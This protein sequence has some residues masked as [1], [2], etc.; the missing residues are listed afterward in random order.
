ML[1]EAS[2]KAF[3]DCSTIFGDTSRSEGSREKYLHTLLQLS[4]CS[5]LSPEELL[6]LPK[7]ETE[8]L[9]QGFAGSIARNGASPAYVNSVIMRLRI[10]FRVNGYV[11]KRELKV[12]G[13]FVPSA[14]P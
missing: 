13:Y 3:R 12:H 2:Y 9:V 1:G 8:L 6:R 4:K 14:V 10:F 7:R 5:G 11:G